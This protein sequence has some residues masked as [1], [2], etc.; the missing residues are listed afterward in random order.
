MSIQFRCE[1]CSQPIEVDDD[2]AGQWVACPFCGQTSRAPMTSD[3]GIQVDVPVAAPQVGLGQGGFATAPMP[4]PAVETRRCVLG[5]IALACLGVCMLSLCVLM[6]VVVP[7]VADLGANADP[8]TIQK[9]V[10]EKQLAS[11][12][13]TLA[14]FLCSLTPAAGLTLAIISLARRESP[15]WPAITALAISAFMAVIVCF[16]VL[17]QSMVPG[18]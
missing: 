11:L 4:T 18:G 12:W 10:V 5:W 15:R 16:G 8:A 9:A 3:A 2:G 14:G 1:S 6:S 7:V 17:A 13:A